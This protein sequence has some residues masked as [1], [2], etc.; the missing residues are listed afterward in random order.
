[1]IDFVGGQSN[2]VRKLVMKIV[3]HMQGICHA[4]LSGGVQEKSGSLFGEVDGP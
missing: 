4:I 2:L 1:M 3:P